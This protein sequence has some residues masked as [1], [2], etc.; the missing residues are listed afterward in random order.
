[1]KHRL[2]L[3]TNPI[4]EFLTEANSNIQNPTHSGTLYQPPHIPTPILIPPTLPPNILPSPKRP[5]PLLPSP[6]SSDNKLETIYQH[7][8]QW[9][10]PRSKVHNI[11]R[12]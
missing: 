3:I 6:M 11:N 4:Y 5:I 1:M 8:L 12:K 10:K 2:A 9:Y 7:N